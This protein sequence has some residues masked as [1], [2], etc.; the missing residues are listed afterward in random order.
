MF[1]HAPTINRISATKTCQTI[2]FA[3]TA[4]VLSSCGGGGG[5]G[6][7]TGVGSVSTNYPH[8][9]STPQISYT[10]NV[11][12]STKYDVTITVNATGPDGVY[13]IS[14]WIHS[15]DN[16]YIFDSLDLVNVGGNTWSAITNPWL[17]LPAGNYYLDSIMVED[18]DPFANGIVKSSWYS[19]LSSSNSHYYVDQRET[20][21]D[22]LNLAILNFNI[23]DNSTPVVNFTLP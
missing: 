6:G 22:P 16:P 4:L 9:T 17:S 5:G 2:L 8:L 14:L 13:A 12:D 3:L 21:W 1:K 19:R 15:K 7:G 11:T 18:G 10:E 23:S 20:N